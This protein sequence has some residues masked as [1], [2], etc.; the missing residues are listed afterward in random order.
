MKNSIGW[1]GYKD[2][3]SRKPFLFYCFDNKIEIITCKDAKKPIMA[4]D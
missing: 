1:I 3:V 2:I 4:S